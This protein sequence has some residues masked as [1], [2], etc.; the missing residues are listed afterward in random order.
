[1]SFL[2]LIVIL[3]ILFQL[4]SA[5]LAVRLIRITRSTAAWLFVALAV[6]LMTVRRIESLVFLLSGGHATTPNLVFEVV[7]LVI[8][9]FMMAGMYLIQPLFATIVRSKEEISAAKEKLSILSR[10]QQLLLDFTRDFIYRHDPQGMITYVSPAVERITGFAPAEWLRHYSAHYTSNPQNEAGIKVTEAM[11]QTGKAGPPYIIEVNHREGGTVWLEINKQ[12]YL[13]D[14]N[15]AGFIGVARDI[16]RR[17]QLDKERS[18]LIA[19]LQDAMASIKSL[20]GLLPICASC[21]KIRDDQ[22]YWSQIEVYISE[23]SDA[24]FSHGI[25]PDCARRLYPD[26]ADKA[27]Q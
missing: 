1:V 18:A 23:H 24:E 19:E 22:G 20:K 7:G 12:P 9:V 13:E 5:I 8:S 14:G 6:I 11:L 26:L 27:G 16:T 25:C 21:K 4:L 10:E 2:T 3:S 17:V 15:V